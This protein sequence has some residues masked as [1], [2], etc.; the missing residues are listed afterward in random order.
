MKLSQV[1]QG[2][3]PEIAEQI[4]KMLVS[5]LGVDSSHVVAK[6][7][8]SLSGDWLVVYVPARKWQMAQALIAAYRQGRHDMLSPSG[9]PFQFEPSTIKLD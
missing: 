5:C 3:L 2:E 8:P 7:H 1:T 4:R 9:S 6:P